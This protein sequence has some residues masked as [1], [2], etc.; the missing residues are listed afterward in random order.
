[1]NR[2]EKN[3]KLIDL[4]KIVKSPICRKI[5]EII[6]GPLEKATSLDRI[7]QIYA[8]IQT[9]RKS[10]AVGD[11]FFQLCMNLLHI[12][13]KLPAFDVKK[14]PLQGPLM[15]VAN[16][17]FGGAEAIVMG[18]LLRKIR[19]DIKFLGNYLLA[20][21]DEIKEDVIPV[22]PFGRKESMHLN[23][24]ALKQSI[25]WLKSGGV[26]ITF[27]AGEVSHIHLP[28]MQVI[29]AQWHPF[30]G[31]VIRHAKTTVLP[32][33][34]SGRNSIM[35]NL[36]GLIH[37]R[38]RTLMLPHE[39]V[40]KKNKTIEMNIG[41]PLYWSKL[42]AFHEN[43]ELMNYLRFKT[44]FLRHRYDR[45]LFRRVQADSPKKKLTDQSPVMPPVSMFRLRRDVCNI[46]P[47]NLLLE[48]S[49][50]AVY[51]ARSDQIPNVL[52]EIGR[53]RELTF[54]D[55]HEGTGGH[56]DLDEFDS[57]YL[58][59][60]LW[61]RSSN[62][63]VGAYRLGP[64][65]L[66]LKKAGARGLYTHTLFRFRSSFLA[67]MASALEIGRSFIRAEYQKNYNSLLMLWQGIGRFVVL[68]PQYRILFGPVSISDAYQNVSKNLMVQFLERHKADDQL[69][70]SVRPRRPYRYYRFKSAK[71]VSDL[72]RTDNMEEISLLISEIEKDGKGMPVL[73]KHYLKLNARI[74]SFNVDKNFSNV[75]DSLIKVDLMETD[76][77]MLDRLMGVEGRKS[78]YCY[79][80]CGIQKEYDVNL[81]NASGAQP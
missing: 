6:Q 52:K 26:L 31:S 40:K 39:L 17:P 9:Q 44:Y 37:P 57:N 11:E 22:D 53:L 81:L 21:I 56:V 78:F 38:L 29:D 77:R 14:I 54:R 62:E 23:M 5:V 12:Q 33:Y 42:S 45:S 47:E 3:S 41:T 59:L 24:K 63:V 74:L 68:H 34:F 36:V 43:T 76:S 1:M 8:I 49:D 30:L 55:V 75:V 51:V 64:V 35:F 16:H 7:N 18:M 69:L 28:R 48:K 73:L 46:A 66:I 50:L 65:D 4:K 72:S 27:P 2:D 15:I 10:E 71:T 25:Q 20:R 80:R 79:H 32:I 13:Y 67:Q 58:H 19:P 60:F 70:G 61:N